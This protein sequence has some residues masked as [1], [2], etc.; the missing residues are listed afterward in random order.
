M[1]NTNRAAFG[2]NFLR[3]S[4]ACLVA[5]LV[6]L[7]SAGPA[8]A[9]GPT[10]SIGEI[11]SKT[12]A[13]Y[14]NIHAF[15]AIFS[16]KTVSAAATNLGAQ[17]AG[18]KLYYAKPRQMRWQYD[19]PQKQIFVANNK[20]AWLSSSNEKQINLFEA[21]KLFASP[22]ASTFFDGA[23]RL[24]DHFHVTLDPVLSTPQTAV[25]QLTP[26]HQD[27]NIKLAY[28]WIDLR[29]YLISRVETQDLLG[30]TNEITITSFTPRTSLDPALFRLQVPPGAKVL[31]ANGRILT[32]AGIEQLQS[33]ISSGK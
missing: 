11:L 18:G 14:R 5:A 10:L 29:T 28:L 13:N 6:L 26:L 19:K 22:L 24:R 23:L 15:T 31:D 4:S 33:E 8:P 3:L 16:Q 9:A 32:N 21:Q 30:N 20:F 2:K 25:L 1:N 17:K 12:E 27:P 7:C